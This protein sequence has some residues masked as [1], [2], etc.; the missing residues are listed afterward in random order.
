MLATKMT[1]I[2]N[3]DCSAMVS[4]IVPPSVDFP[5]PSSPQESICDAPNGPNTD[6]GP[7]SLDSEVISCPRRV[8]DSRSMAD[9]RPSISKKFVTERPPVFSRGS[10][11]GLHRRYTGQ[12]VTTEATELNDA[13]WT[14]KFGAKY[15]RDFSDSSSSSSSDNETESKVHQTS[16]ARQR[17]RTA[18]ESK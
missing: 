5:Y 12:Q 18:S 8:E 1:N 4:T 17:A 3:T 6:V 10:S 7:V 2:T 16:S 15:A 9:P 11:V 14:Q 13:V